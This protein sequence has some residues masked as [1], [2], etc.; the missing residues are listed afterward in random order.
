MYRKVWERCRYSVCSIDFISHAGTKIISF[1]GFKVKKYLITDDIVDKFAK[2]AVVQLRFTECQASGSGCIQMSF[3]DFLS[4][5]VSFGNRI[6]PGFLIFEITDKTFTEVPPLLC[7]RKI[8][9][10]IGHPIALLG[11]QL[12]RDHLA[13]KSGIISSSFTSSEGI[14]TIQI[15]CTIK[16]GNA[17]SPLICAE[18]L[19]VIGVIGHRLSAIARNYQVMMRIINTNLKVLKEA[20]GK[21]NM[22]ELDP[23]QVLIANQNQIKHLMRELYKSTHMRTGFAIE[24]STLTDYCPDYDEDIGSIETE[25]S[26]DN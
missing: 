12:D 17:G 22:E 13:L 26:V 24:L 1:T 19:E 4:S 9:Y 25:I 23:I 15:D 21:I 2:P 11:Y 5:K 16:Q 8:N 6:H 20:E 14:N 10:P 7:A 18:T 3:K